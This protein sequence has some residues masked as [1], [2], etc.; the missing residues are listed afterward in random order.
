MADW[1]E[2]RLISEMI[3]YIRG[4]AKGLATK[5]KISFYNDE[6]QKRRAWYQWRKT[7][8]WSTSNFMDS[9]MSIVF[10]PIKAHGKASQT[11]LVS[12][13]PLLHLQYDKPFANEVASTTIYQQ[14]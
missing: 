8:R 13:F 4:S 1:Y 6:L 9:P 11:D 12:K 2:I 14:Q 7:K 3:N 10:T 5:C